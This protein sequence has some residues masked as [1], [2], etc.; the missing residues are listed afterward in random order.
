MGCGL[1]AR[2]CRMARKPEKNHG[3]G[4]I[5]SKRKRIRKKR[6]S[7]NTDHIFHRLFRDHP[8]W[9]RELTG[10]P[11]PEGCRGSAPSFKQA[12]VQCDL[13]LEPAE[14]SDPC[15]LVEFQLYHDHSIFNRIELARQLLWK[16]LN[17]RKDCRRRDYWPRE[18]ETVILFGTRKELPSSHGL[19]PRTGVLFLDELL[20]ALGKENPESPLRAALAP[21]LDSK[22]ELEKR[23]LRHYNLI[24]NSPGL[25]GEDKTIL[26]EAFEELLYQLFDNENWEDFKKMIAEL[27][28]LHK[29]RLGKELVQRSRQEGQMSL[30]RTMVSKGLSPAE[31]ANLT[32]LSVEEI[33]RFLALEED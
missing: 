14:P 10:L 16:R 28:P 18:V 6:C 11:L 29:T 32:D 13:L 22:E 7:L 8:E 23:A 5:R 4:T 27:T 2:Y 17:P 3:L 24:E 19:H 12:E 21:V 31:I 25:S 33:E 26:K 9:L 15:F 1:C 30:V 20:D